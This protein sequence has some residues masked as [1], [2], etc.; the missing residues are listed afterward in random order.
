MSE[1]KWE[2][3]DEALAILKVRGIKY[4]LR[5]NDVELVFEDGTQ[6]WPTTGTIMQ[7]GKRLDTKGID[8]LLEAVVA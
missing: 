7:D 1:A 3:Y 5:N 6:Y 8:A 4:E 2:R